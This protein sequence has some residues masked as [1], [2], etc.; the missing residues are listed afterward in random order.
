MSHFRSFL[1]FSIA[2]LLGGCAVPMPHVLPIVIVPTQTPARYAES[3]LN[4][5]VAYVL[6]ESDRSKEVWDY[7]SMLNHVG[8]FP[9]RDLEKGI[10]DAL[11][12]VYADVYVIRSTKDT[13]AIKS[14][15]IS[16]IFIP[17]ISTNSSASF[18]GPTLPTKFNIEVSFNVTDADGELVSRIQAKGTGAAEVSEI[19]R[20]WGLAG[21][22]AANNFSE[23]LRKAVSADQKLR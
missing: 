18:S 2:T 14:K 13:N 22:R 21:Q 19:G 10:R 23:N 20:D 3:L 6:S 7:M 16:Y 11:R 1:A 9:N 4:K 15:N 12:A 17:E 8:Y 5:N